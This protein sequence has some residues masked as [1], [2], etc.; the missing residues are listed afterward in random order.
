M[1]TESRLSVV[2]ATLGG[3]SLKDT[4]NSLM[5]GSVQP[6]E[7]LICIPET[8]VE[9]VKYLGDEIVRVVPTTVKG[10]VKQRS[11]GF[12]EATC[13]LVMQLD[14]DVVFEND[15]I[16]KL[17]QILLKMGKGN[18]LAP[19]YYDLQSKQCIHRLSTGISA[20]AKNIFDMLICAAPWGKRKMGKITSIGINYGIDD[21]LCSSELMA[22]QWVP[23]GCVLS[24]REDLVLEDY[25]PFE[26]KAYCEDLFLSYYRSKM[27]LKSWVAPRIKIFTELTPPEYD[28]QTVEKV[29]AIRRVYLKL[30]GGPQWRLWLYDIFCRMRSRIYS[31]FT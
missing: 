9:K 11:V 26:G 31:L 30:T 6:N 18:V 17:V 7:I 20:L 23:G 27:H 12:R 15:S 8:Y 24:F 29:I 22:V 4:I 3:D 10:Q 28:I 19:V 16:E 21:V 2:I 5:R 14:D 25:F 1:N 13:E